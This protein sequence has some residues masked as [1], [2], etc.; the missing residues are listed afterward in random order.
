MNR[1]DSD[2]L[3]DFDAATA[4]YQVGYKDASQFSRDYKRHFGYAPIPWLIIHPVH[5]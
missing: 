3:D 4:G 5:S 2:L 1:L